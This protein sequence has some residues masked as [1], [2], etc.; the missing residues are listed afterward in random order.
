LQAGL[1]GLCIHERLDG[2]AN[3]AAAQQGPVEFA[4][5][6]VPAARNRPDP[7][8]MAVDGNRR[9][10]EVRG[11]FLPGEVGRGINLHRPVRKTGQRFNLGQPVP[12]AFFCHALQLAVNRCVDLQTPVVETI[13]VNHE[14]KFAEDRV[15]RPVIL[16]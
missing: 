11:K 13:A 3:L 4:A 10:F 6:V 9:A 16:R 1:K 7:A 14:L 15:H 8:G 2:G 12:K 5:F